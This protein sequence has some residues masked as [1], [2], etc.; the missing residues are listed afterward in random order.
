MSGYVGDMTDIAGD[1]TPALMTGLS[2][3]APHA[4]CEVKT[5]F[6]KG[7]FRQLHAFYFK[8][9]TYRESPTSSDELTPTPSVSL[10]S[11]PFASGCNSLAVTPTHRPSQVG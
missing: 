11:S 9:L 1:I 5:I 3:T 10:G 4:S 7:A 8:D 2:L 6:R